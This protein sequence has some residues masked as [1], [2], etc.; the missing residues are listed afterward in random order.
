MP[1]LLDTNACITHL[2]SSGSA[3]VTNR[4]FETS[5]GEVV[6]CSVVK[7]ELVYGAM[8]SHDVS[9]NMA[10]LSQFFSLFASLPFDDRAADAYGRLRASLSQTGS[11]IGPNDL[12]IAAIALSNDLTLVTHNTDEFSRVPD[13][14]VEDWE[15]ASS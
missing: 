7:G 15:S 9:G 4:L 13:L 2:R 12:M 3:F 1:Y 14:T 10:R 11:L 5:P 6:R 8:R